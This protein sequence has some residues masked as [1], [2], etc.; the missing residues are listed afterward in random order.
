VS[1]VTITYMTWEVHLRER[2]GAGCTTERVEADTWPN[3]VRAAV[4]QANA[5]AV[6]EG[7]QPGIYGG[8]RNIEQVIYEADGAPV[9]GTARPVRRM[10]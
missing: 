6:A 3:A 2:Y 9:A 7:C 5:E 10:S 4:M 1:T 8:P